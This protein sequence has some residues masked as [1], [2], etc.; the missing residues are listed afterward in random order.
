VNCSVSRPSHPARRPRPL[1][2][3]RQTRR[4]GEDRRRFRRPIPN[5]EVESDA[6]AVRVYR[7]LAPEYAS[8]EREVLKGR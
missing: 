5:R 6:A 1:R 2:L 8:I 7:D 4:V 3:H